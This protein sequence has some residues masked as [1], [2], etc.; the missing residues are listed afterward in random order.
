[1]GLECAVYDPRVIGKFTVPSAVAADKPSEVAAEI[2]RVFFDLALR[3]L[4]MI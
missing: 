2:G 1:M 4:Q 3:A